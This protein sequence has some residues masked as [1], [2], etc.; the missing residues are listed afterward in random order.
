MINQILNPSFLLTLTALAALILG[1]TQAVK[2]GIE[3]AIKRPVGKPIAVLISF[4]VSVFLASPK[5]TPDGFWMYVVFAVA[6]FITANGWF[7]LKQ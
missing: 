1:S 2:K 7:K 5:I 3:E 6:G 4:V